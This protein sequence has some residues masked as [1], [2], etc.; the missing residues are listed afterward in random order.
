M[1][2]AVRAGVGARQLEESPQLC[3]GLL[4]V[5][6]AGACGGLPSAGAVKSWSSVV[7]HKGVGQ[8]LCFP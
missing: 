8:L 1:L 2:A 4:L 5:W 7:L 6:E 3:T